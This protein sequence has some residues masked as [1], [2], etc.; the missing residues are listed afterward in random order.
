ML[1][2]FGG[3]GCLTRLSTARLLAIGLA[4]SGALFAQNMT[5][6]IPSAP[7]SQTGAQPAA[8]ASVPIIGTL[9]DLG[10]LVQKTYP[11][12]YDDI[13]P[14]EIGRAM[15]RKYP[16]AFDAFGES[17]NALPQRQAGVKPTPTSGVTG[18]DVRWVDNQ[19]GDYTFMVFNSRK[20]DIRNVTCEVVFYD[21]AGKTIDTDTVRYAGTIPAGLPRRL[22]S[23][24]DKSVHEYTAP[25]D[26]LSVY[27]QGYQLIPSTRIEVRVVD[28]EIAR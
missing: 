21:S 20:S 23:K 10:R 3:E 17:Q 27:P 4:I 12:A 25:V 7:A 28:F 16:G 24:V 5:V 13:D 1:E 9:T 11:G 22:T 8:P 6:S 26:V 2:L 14:I 15:Q 19:T 18:S